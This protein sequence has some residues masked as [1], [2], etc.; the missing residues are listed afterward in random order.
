MAKLS[1]EPNPFEQSFSLAQTKGPAPGDSN[2]APPNS[3]GADAAQDG[4]DK[5]HRQRPSSTPADGLGPLSS[6]HRVKLPPVAAINGPIEGADMSGKWG[7]E[8]L[9]SGPL[10]PAMLGRPTGPPAARATARATP[11][12]GVSDPQLH[13]GLTPFIAS[14]THPAAPAVGF[15]G[16]KRTRTTKQRAPEPAASA[17]NTKEESAGDDDEKR[18]LFLERNRQ[19]AF[20]CR[21]RKK[22]HLQE[23]QERYDYVVADN[24]RLRAE[25]AQ[26]R[27]YAMRARALLAA[28]ADCPVARANGVFGPDALT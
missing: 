23:L 10:S 2:G 8:S 20:K 26:L 28:H 27:D 6:L 13:T 5:R 3:Y 16:A 11:R 4:A 1:Q 21:Q 7:A 14:E 22:Q 19:A 12:L 9:R 17:A 18:K 24:E 15:N 25:F